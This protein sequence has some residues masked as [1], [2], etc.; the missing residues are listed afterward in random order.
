MWS[1]VIS[2]L[3]QRDITATSPIDSDQQQTTIVIHYTTLTVLAAIVF[4][5]VNQWCV[6]K[7]VNFADCH[8]RFI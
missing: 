2:R 5:H 8:R 6:Q 7:Q 4:V 1:T 3:R